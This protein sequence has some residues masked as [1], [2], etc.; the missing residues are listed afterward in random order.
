[1]GERAVPPLAVSMGEPA[2]VG[3]D[4]VLALYA[5]RQAN[6]L[7]PFIVY[8]QAAFL[9]NRAARL[10]LDV[11]IDTA[12]PETAVALFPAALPVV[13]VEGLLPDKPGAPTP[14]SA[15]AVQNAIAEAVRAT[16]AGACRG[17][18]TAPIHK[19]VLYTSGFRYPGHTEYLA[20]LCANGSPPRQPVMMLVHG[21]L[22]AVPLTVHVPLAQVPGLVTAELIIN[23]VRTVVHD[24]KTRFGIAEPRIAVSG[25]N[26]HAGEGGGIGMEELEVIGPAIAELKFENFDV[27]GPLPADTLFYPPHW[28]RYHAVIAMYH[29]QALIPVKTVAFD[30]AVNITLGLPIVRTS[31]DHGTAFDLAGTGKASTASFLAALRL[32]D[33]LTANHG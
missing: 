33:R 11:E 3:P 17:L 12:T 9:R 29:D 5:E 24:L 14:V 13:E 27:E 30:K 28:R 21:D 4:I 6:G 10:G 32:A 8:G 23:T 7:S 22:R 18:V 2:G 26:P 15:T 1:M 25:L 19:A 20:A 31:P 16:L